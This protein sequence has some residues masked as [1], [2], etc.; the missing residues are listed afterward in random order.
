LALWYVYIIYSEK[1]DRYYVGYCDDLDWRLDR[2]NWGW[3]RY[4]KSGIPWRLVYHEAYASKKEAMGRERA[5]KQ[6]KSRK[7][8]ESLIKG[9]G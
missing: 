6:K 7:Y 4:T 5:I 8:I 1:L 2:H 9:K 3:G